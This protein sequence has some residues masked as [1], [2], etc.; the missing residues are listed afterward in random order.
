MGFLEV[1]VYIDDAL[2]DYAPMFFKYL[3]DAKFMISKISII[4]SM[5]CDSNR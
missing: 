1:Y 5:N 2:P 4:H 3:T